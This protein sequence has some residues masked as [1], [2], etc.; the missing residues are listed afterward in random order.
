MQRKRIE[1]ICS[2]QEGIP[3]EDCPDIIS[4]RYFWCTTSTRLRETDL[5]E[6]KATFQAN[7][8]PSA[9]SLGCFASIAPNVTSRSMPMV[10]GVREDLLTHIRTEGSLTIGWDCSVIEI[11]GLFRIYYHI[12]GLQHSLVQSLTLEI[13][14]CLQDTMIQVQWKARPEILR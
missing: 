6:T 2:S 12:Q 3:D 9:A 1:R 7:V 4:E 13:R 11:R 10:P 14:R 5:V 8:T